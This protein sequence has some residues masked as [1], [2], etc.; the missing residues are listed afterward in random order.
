[1]YQITII[2]F[3]LITQ[4]IEASKIVDSR[5]IT[6]KQGHDVVLSCRFQQ[7][8]ERDR[9]MWLKGD[10][11][12]SVNKDISGERKKYE[13]TDKYDLIIKTVV[14]QDSGRYLCQNFDQALSINVLLTVLTKPTQ[15]DLQQLNASLIE[16]HLGRFLCI[17]QGGNPLPTFH[18]LINEIKIN[19]SLYK[20]YLNTSKSYS[21]LYLPLE[22]HL[23][24]NSLTCQVQNQALDKP[25]I[26]S[27]ALNILHKPEVRLRANGKN[28]SNLN[29]IFT[30]NEQF[31]IDCAID[32]NPSPTKPLVW[33]KNGVLISSSTSSSLTLQSI[34][35]TDDGEYTCSSTNSIGQSHSSVYIRVQYSPIV[36]INGGGIINESEKLILICNV[37][38]YPMIDYYQWYKNNEKL[39]TSS[40]TSSI[41]IEKVSK[42]D[43][44]NYVCMVKNTLKYSN[45]S[46]I[47]KLNK[48]QT[49]IIV[50]YAP[51][52]YTIDSI[53]AADIR[54]TNIKFQCEIDSYPKSEIR[55]KFQNKFLLNST[56]YFMIQNQSL[57]YLILQQIQSNTDYGIYS[58]NA[59]NKLG[60]NSTTIQLR[61]KDVPDSP[62]DLNIT[63]ISYSTISIEWKAGYN[64]GWPQTFWIS[65]DNS[66]WKETNQTYFTLTNLQ[67]LEYYNIT[68]RA[69]NKLGQS[70]TN[71][72][73]RVQTKDLPIKREDLSIL[74]HS[75][76]YL[77]EKTLHYGLN[78]TSFSTIKIP[79]CIRIE[80][81]NQTY[82][83]QRIVTSSGLI[84]LD[85]ID[86]NNILY[87]SICLNQY[88]HFCGD[89]ISVDIKRETSF[90][91]IFI[92]VSSII[93]VS[94]LILCGLCIFCFI[95]NRKQR[96][97]ATHTLVSIVSKKSSQSPI[98]IE[99]IPNNNSTKFFSNVTYPE[100]QPK[101]SS[102]LKLDQLQG[103]LSNDSNDPII[104]SLS[105][106][107]H[108]T[109]TDFNQS[110]HH[111]HTSQNEN[112]NYG[113]PFYAIK[114]KEDNN[115]EN[116]YSTPLK[117][118][119]LNKKTVY[120]VVV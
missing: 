58:C 41:I 114:T 7:L 86:L 2:V 104:T 30:E 84:K 76:I 63:S 15:P 116:I 64:G 98:I 27:F 39:N 48:S 44:G 29:L 21:E 105:N 51:K 74:E 12:I 96:R 69:Y 118:D 110:D 85:E 91:W 82:I 113:F 11:V 40:L 46:S 95:F 79:L 60:Y 19:E 55:W 115:T 8:N 101:P 120:E 78:D 59:N 112:I 61:S 57:S 70:S 109:V 117:F 42:Y 26:T 72:F 1:M 94:L 34:K 88:E 24:N 73:L 80:I 43:S 16:N 106:S 49:E 33:L 23:H 53:I 92:L 90:N 10:T 87:V 28:I 31:T 75:S 93:V 89:S 107:E 111:L 71:A 22:K 17:T 47:E 18:W 100:Q 83:C 37:K 103:N 67:H 4:L 102:Y 119:Q 50:Q 13:I 25:L 54:E 3:L 35:R 81:T 20:N 56:K 62:T 32:S 38:S 52:V 66:L 68:V 9:V 65:L 99:S 97:N 45:G 14:D 77:F 108:L 6:E 36:E 5:T